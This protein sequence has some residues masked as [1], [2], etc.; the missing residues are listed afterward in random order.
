MAS[1]AEGRTY[2]FHKATRLAQWHRPTGDA[3]G[4]EGARRPPP[5]PL[6]GNPEELV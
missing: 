1:D 2:Y 4:N 5:A 6:A 3:D